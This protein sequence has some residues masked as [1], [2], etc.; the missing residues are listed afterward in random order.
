VAHQGR[1]I[2]PL[3]GASSKDR[4]AEAVGAIVVRFDDADIAA[5]QTA[6]PLNQV[7]GTRYPVPQMAYL[8]SKH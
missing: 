1:D 8:D 6:M 4:L 5:T 2:N 3:I 7:A